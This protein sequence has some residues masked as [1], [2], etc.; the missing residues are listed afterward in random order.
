MLA[1]ASLFGFSWGSPPAADSIAA[2]SLS[3]PRRKRKTVINVKLKPGGLSRFGY[4]ADASVRSRHAALLRAARSEGFVPIIQRLNLIAT[5]SKNR[6]P[7][8][9]RIFKMD[10]RWLSDYYAA[11]K[12]REGRSSRRSRSSKITASFSGVG[13]SKV[14]A[15][16]YDADN[17]DTAYDE[18]EDYDYSPS[19]MGDTD[20]TS[21]SSSSDDDYD[22]DE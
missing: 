6:S 10:Q 17:D 1:L 9:S 5:F 18:D 20:T 11:V 12:E 3:A 4:S 15:K 8:Y 22:S 16:V 2:E 7:G 14:P 19:E 13:Q 21:S